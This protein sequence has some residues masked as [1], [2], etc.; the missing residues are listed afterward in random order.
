MNI[1]KL[2]NVP[3]TNTIAG[4]C[5]SNNQDEHE[6]FSTEAKPKLFFEYMNRGDPETEN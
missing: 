3:K 4:N 1:E 6:G 5:T 2:K